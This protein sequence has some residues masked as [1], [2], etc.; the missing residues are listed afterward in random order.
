[1][2]HAVQPLI[3]YPS[4]RPEDPRFAEG[5]VL[6]LRMAREW[7]ARELN[8]KTFRL[9]EPVMFRSQF[10]ERELHVRHRRDGER[11]EAELWTGAMREA[12]HC[13]AVTGGPD[14]VYYF[15]LVG[16]GWTGRAWQRDYFGCAAYIAGQAAEVMAGMRESTRKNDY[17]KGL[18]AAAGL[19]AHEL[20]HCFSYFGAKHLDNLERLD[21]AW[22]NLMGMGY[23]QFPECILNQDQRESLS[24]SPFLADTGTLL[25]TWRA[26]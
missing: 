19:M 22:D 14:R 13:G 5:A 24:A 10:S 2:E 3:F 1:M 11:D 20:A 9:A 8:G 16:E 18:T 6:C 23:T 7:F 17:L 26:V 12:I 15:V 4:N 21:G 25:S